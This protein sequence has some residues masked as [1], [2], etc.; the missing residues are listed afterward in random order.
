MRFWVLGFSNLTDSGVDL[1]GQDWNGEDF[2][3]T[4]GK[5]EGV[6]FLPGFQI[7]REGVTGYTA[8]SR[9]TLHTDELLWDVLFS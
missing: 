1:E 4:E 2:G 9:V 8:Q 6:I 7:H 5:R 3:K